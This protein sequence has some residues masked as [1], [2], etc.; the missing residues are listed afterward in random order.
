MGHGQTGVAGSYDEHS[1]EPMDNLPGGRR[2][3]SR[4]PGGQ[5]RGK[6]QGVARPLL[7][8]CRYS[9][10]VRLSFYALLLLRIFKLHMYL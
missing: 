1:Q 7:L 2:E 3:R 5:V 4:S 10:A 8:T 9:A 6:W